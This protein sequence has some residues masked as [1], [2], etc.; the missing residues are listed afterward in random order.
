MIAFFV[1]VLRSKYKN[2]AAFGPALIFESAGGKVVQRTSESAGGTVVQRMS[3]ERLRRP[4][5]IRAFAERL[6][7]PRR[8]RAFAERLRRPRRIRFNAVFAKA[9]KFF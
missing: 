3:A 4:Q 2:H 8:I 1:E 7:R 9:R 6:R 5:R